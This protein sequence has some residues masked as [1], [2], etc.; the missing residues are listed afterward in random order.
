MGYQPATD[1]LGMGDL[2][3]ESPP[4]IVCL[5]CGASWDDLAAFRRGDAPTLPQREEGTADPKASGPSG[6][7]ASSGSGGANA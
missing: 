7:T 5:A 2:R 1:L 3:P 4:R 6:P